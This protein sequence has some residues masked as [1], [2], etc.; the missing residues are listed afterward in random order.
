MP[1][2]YHID[3]ATE[4]GRDTL[5]QTLR[6]IHRRFAAKGDL[7]GMLLVA[8]SFDFAKRMD[9][10]LQANKIALGVTGPAIKD[11]HPDGDD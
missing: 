6:Y 1:F 5:C 3:P 2:K 4:T 10:K 8:K 11:G 9:A 7:D